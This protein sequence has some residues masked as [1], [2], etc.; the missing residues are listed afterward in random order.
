VLT[1]VRKYYFF[2]LLI[3]ITLS[4]NGWSLLGV[5]IGQLIY[6]LIL[7]IGVSVLL[8]SGYGKSG[9]FLFGLTLSLKI[10]NGLFVI[11]F[12]DV[13]SEFTSGII[14]ILVGASLYAEY[15]NIIYRQLIS[16]FALSIPFMIVQK[17]GIHTFFY[18]WST[19]LFH[20]NGTYSFDVV[21][22]L[23]VIF[24]NIPLVKTLFVEISDL[25]YVMYQGRPTG[26]LYSNNVLSVIISFALAL[27][28]SI[29]HRVKRN[30]NNVVI[31][32]IAVLTMS[33]MVYGV[34]LLLFMYFY[35][36]NRSKH[37]KYNAVK[38]LFVTLVML[39]FH[40]L[41][42]PGLTLASIGV[43]NAVSFVTRFAE[44]FNLLGLNY[45]DDVIVLLDMKLY[46]IDEDQSFSLV[47][48]LL[49]N[50]FSFIFLIGLLLIM[51]IYYKNLKKYPGPVIIYTSLFYVCIMTQFGVNFLR[52]P[53]F[54]LFFGIALYPI[55][56]S[57]IVGLKSAN[58][59]LLGA[60]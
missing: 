3:N 30:F 21:E 12:V 7:L 27:H 18:G 60:Y 15:P 6:W 26:L 48:A 57:R 47:G 9:L 25:Q 35:F 19:E 51:N 2:L 44:I 24:K 56:R 59:R 52:A 41:F 38:T 4:A 14:L 5:S 43:V 34:I 8:K 50:R 53:S 33:T 13:L 32:T 46:V 29:N 45:F 28:F 54:Q 39:L 58:S 37:L 17:I 55:F 42:F 36:I 22:D 16:F 20:T 40:F 1:Q 49:K 31:A 10:I 23:G 11:T